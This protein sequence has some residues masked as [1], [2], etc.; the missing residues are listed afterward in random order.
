MTA[1]T[2]HTL[3]AMGVARLREATLPLRQTVSAKLGLPEVLELDAVLAELNRVWAA[4]QKQAALRPGSATPAALETQFVADMETKYGAELLDHTLMMA[5]YKGFAEGEGLARAEDIRRVPE[6]AGQAPEPIR[7]ERLTS[8]EVPPFLRGR[9]FGALGKYGYSPDVDL[10]GVATVVNEVLGGMSPANTQVVNIEP[11][12]FGKPGFQQ[13]L[14]EQFERLNAHHEKSRLLGLEV[15]ERG[16]C[17]AQQLDWLRSQRD[18]YR[19]VVGYD[20]LTGKAEDYED[21]AILQ[22]DYVKLDGPFVRRAADAEFKQVVETVAARCPAA[23]ICAEWTETVAEYKKA[24][25]FGV[26]SVQSFKLNDLLKLEPKAGDFTV[27]DLQQ[28]AQGRQTL[29]QVRQASPSRG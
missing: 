2:T 3:A 28:V 13:A 26:D 14:T 21:I 22:P 27:A 10:L 16:R 20:D 15:T 4:R 6:K 5:I 12:S 9:T 11:A 17:T 23:Q 1:L 18:T 7:Q 29:A 8:A 19:F 24:A 25:Q